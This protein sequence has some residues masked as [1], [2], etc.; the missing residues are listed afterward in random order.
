MRYIQGASRHQATL[1]PEVLD[2]FIHETNPVRFI[3]AFV[4]SLDLIRLGFTHSETKATGRKP[5][6][7]GDLLKLYIYGHLNRIRSSR[8]LETATQRNI[9]VMW[10]LCRLSP[11]FKTIADFRKDNHKGLKKVL[12]EFILLCKKLDLLGGELIAIDGS[13]FKADNHNG[14]NYSQSKVKRLL[15]QIDE[16]VDAY[17][18]KLD[19]ADKDENPTHQMNVQELRDKIKNLEKHKQ[20]LKQLEQSIKESGETQIS[21]TDKDSRKMRVSSGGTDMCYNAQA[22]VDSKH[23]LIVHAEVTSDPTDHNLLSTVAVQAKETLNVETIQAVAD[24]GYF[25]FEEIKACLDQDIQCFVPRPKKSANKKKGLFTNRDFRYDK[26]NDCYICPAQQKLNYTGITKL[27]GRELKNYRAR[28]CNTCPLKAKC[29]TSKGNRKIRR[30][31]HEDILEAMQQRLEKQPQIMQL[32]KQLVEHPFG[33]IKHWMGHRH[34]LTRGLEKV[35][36]E[37]ALAALT[38]NIRRVIN[39]IGVKELVKMVAQ[40]SNEKAE[41]LLYWIQFCYNNLFKPPKMIFQI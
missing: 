17:L 35:S 16:K 13:K 38:Y 31:V 28:K 5:Y 20:E 41:K 21:L 9:E 23:K 39:I 26:F 24:A 15:Q 30:W 25:K 8:T 4:D 11:D 34:F 14:K 12:R 6:S 27:N 29:T 2:D 33:T 1:F 3:D 37:F 22:G 10:L 19:S 40:M 18:K 7:P 32:R 36:G